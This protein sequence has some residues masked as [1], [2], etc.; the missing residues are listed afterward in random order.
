MR[1]RVGGWKLGRNTEHRRALLRNLV[2]SL[3][4]EERI[5]TTVPKAKAMRP[6]VEKMITLGKQGNVAA[7]R[8]AAAYLMTSEAVDKLF[9]TISPRFG[10]REGGYLRIVRTGFRPGD[11]GEKAFIELL[12]SEK[13]IDEKREKRAAARAKRAEDNRKALEAQQAQAEA[14]T[15]GETKA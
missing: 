2:T 9:N 4:V 13:I 11:G 12:G 14:E 8:Q 1:H 6:H 10:D 7:R 15:T 5:E 3:I